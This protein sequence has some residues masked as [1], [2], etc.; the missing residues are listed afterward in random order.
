MQ[1][2]Q[3]YTRNVMSHL[4]QTLCNILD[5]PLQVLQAEAMLTFNERF[6]VWAIHNLEW[7]VLYVVLHTGI[8]ELP[9][10]EPLGIKDCVLRVHS[11]LHAFGRCEA[12][13][14]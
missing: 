6:M 13:A 8:C 7:P 5:L 12:A 14:S 2:T 9:A 1:G 4:Y 3:A 10:D 11:H